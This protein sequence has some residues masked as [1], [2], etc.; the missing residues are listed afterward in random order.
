MMGEGIEYEAKI[1]SRLM[2]VWVIEWRRY[3]KA[4]RRKSVKKKD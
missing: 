2:K 1:D 3:I 4:Q